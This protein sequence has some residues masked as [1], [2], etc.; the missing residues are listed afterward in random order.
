MT[1]C[2]QSSFEFKAHYSREVVARFDGGA[3]SSD[4]GSLLLRET[5]QRLNLLG[6]F[7]R[8]F[9]DGRQQDRVEHSVLEMVAQRVYGLALGYEDLN[10]HEQ[11]RKDPLF[12]V[13]AGR[14]E[15]DRPLAGKS[16]LNRL[17]LG[18]GGRD[19]Y[20]KI[21]F[22]KQEVDELLVSVFLESQAKAPEQIILDVDT[23]DLPYTASKKGASS[24]AITTATAIYRCISSAA[25]MFCARGCGNPTAMLRPG[26]WRR[27]NGSSH[28]FERGGRK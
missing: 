28:R 18:N 9:L 15:F 12:G 21:T 27:S 3:I 19:R 2:T 24:T 26:A 1:Q 20:K 23:T 10:D 16:T 11:L 6:R 13:L 8:C 17:E 25:S 5:D 4:G 7:S 22:W 14:E